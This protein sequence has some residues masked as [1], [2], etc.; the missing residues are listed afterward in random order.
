MSDFRTLEGAIEATY[1][2]L[3]ISSPRD[4]AAFWTVVPKYLQKYGTEHSNK[5]TRNQ[6]EQQLRHHLDTILCHT[7]EKIEVFEYR[8]LA[9]TTLGFAKIV[10][11]IGNRLRQPDDIRQ[12]LHHFFIGDN[13]TNKEFLFGHIAAASMPI[14]QKFDA[15]SLSNFIYAYG[16]SGYVLKF[17][18][19]STLFDILAS[20]TIP[21]LGGFASQGFSNMLWS[22]ANVKASNPNLFKES[23]DVI[24][25]HQNLEMFTP[26]ALSNIVWAYATVDE[27]HHKLFKK[28][29]D[30]VAA[31]DNLRSFNPQGLS[32][33]VW[34]YASVNESHPMLFKKVADHVASL[35]N[36]IGF[37]P[38]A[39]SNIVWAYATVGESHSQLV[40]KVADHVASL[41]SLRSFEPQHL[42][43]IVWAY[44]TLNESH[45]KL[46]QKVAGA[47]IG[48]QDELNSQSISNLAWAFATNGQLDENLLKTLAPTA[49]ACVNKCN[50][51]NLA[52]LAWAYAVANVAAPSLFNDDFI[53]ALLEKQGDL[54]IGNLSQLHQWNLW[55]QELKSDIR[56]PP[57][58][59]EKCHEAFLHRVPKSSKFQ[60]DVISEIIFIGLV[61]E[62]EKLTEKGYRLDA[63][64]E[65]DG[66]KIG[67]EVDGP[68]HFIGE[69]PTGSTIL[70]HRQVTNIERIKIVSVSY[71]E[72]RKLKRDRSKKQQYLRLLLRLDK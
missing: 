34:A 41:D 15:R 13:S 20:K 19:G 65:V 38:Q 40:K 17:E 23:G 43:N 30:H 27:S 3:D 16:L 37:K 49:A 10:N 72:W 44:A 51:Q 47:V 55:Q 36:F 61:P 18:D 58:L 4:M 26:Q 24:T 12:I 66:T 57:S 35:D 45:P 25:A 50:S 8:D 59:R 48:K 28:V 53:N 31:L 42:S 22:Y 33:T 71:W 67:I 54:N 63:L 70:K 56:L 14:L 39:L 32:N 6:G 46:F 62:E 9:Q 52:N 5:H 69:K 7:L 21:K 1:D 60:R 68:S 11:N 2:H 64:V 29:A